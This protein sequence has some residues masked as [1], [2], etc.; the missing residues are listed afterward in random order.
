METEC[1][2]RA[3][4]FH[5]AGSREVVDRFDGGKV[6]SEGGGLLLRELNSLS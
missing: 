6:T 5:V 3:L 4:A 1:T 2:R